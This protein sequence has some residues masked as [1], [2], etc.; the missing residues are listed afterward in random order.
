MPTNIVDIS[1]LNP[2]KLVSVDNKNESFSGD[3]YYDKIFNFE[4]KKRY[5]Q[6]WQ[7]N[8]V[9][10]LQ[11]YSNLSPI[12]IH[13]IGEDGVPANSYVATLKPTNLEDTDFNIYEAS[14][15]LTGLDGGYYMTCV[16]GTGFAKINLRSEPFFVG[17]TIENSLLFKYD[18]SY[19][20]QG[21]IFDTGIAFTFRAEAVVSEF[22]P[23]AKDTI[24]QDQ[25]LNN[26]VLSSIPFRKFKLFVGGPTGVPDYVVDKV[27]RIL[28]CDNWSADGVN[29]VKSD[30]AD[31]EANRL[32][33]YPMA[34]WSI[35]ILEASNLSSQRGS[36]DGNQLQRITVTY[37]IETDLFGEFG[38]NDSVRITEIHKS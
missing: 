13:I 8:D 19:N 17:E 18:N 6:K 27:N 5:C 38:G 9:I 34:G 32:G 25:I 4:D 1:Y 20:D 30:D 12:N 29:Y 10:K 14:I 22:I 31:W 28:S 15:A 23:G 36:N 24:Y 21:I 2:V 16:V 3:F 33:L 7:S 37:N 11:F 26:V 35:S